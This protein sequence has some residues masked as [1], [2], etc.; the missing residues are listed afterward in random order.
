[1]NVNLLTYHQVI[2]PQIQL[3]QSMVLSFMQRWLKLKKSVISRLIL[4]LREIKIIMVQRQLILL[5][6]ALMR[7]QSAV[8]GVSLGN[9]A[10]SNFQIRQRLVC[11]PC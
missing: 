10:T 6:L 7:N 1:M 5:Q 4:L 9:N 8:N 3:M 2:F 11:D